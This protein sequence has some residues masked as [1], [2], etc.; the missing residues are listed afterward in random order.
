[1]F[2]K[3]RLQYSGRISRS[4][5]LVPLFLH[6]SYLKK[7]LDKIRKSCCL[8][9]LIT[10]RLDEA[11]L[12]FGFRINHSQTYKIHFISLAFFERSNI[13]V[14]KKSKFSRKGFVTKHSLVMNLC[15]LF[16]IGFKITMVMF[17]VLF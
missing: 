6:S 9:V 17:F 7:K 15:S 1:M 13:I 12:S 2:L 8:S 10:F 4:T 14:L 16:L 11:L 5:F 3:E